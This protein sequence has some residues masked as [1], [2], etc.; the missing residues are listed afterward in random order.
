MRPRLV[1]VGVVDP[2]AAIRKAM[3]APGSP[4]SSDEV[5]QGDV[6]GHH[7]LHS[8][9]VGVLRI[10][11]D[12][13]EVMN[14]DADL[15][16]ALQRLEIPDPLPPLLARCH[17]LLLLL[18][19]SHSL[20]Q[21][22]VMVDYVGVEVKEEAA[23]RHGLLA[24][25]APDKSMTAGPPV[26]V[27]TLVQHCLAASVRAEVAVLALPLVQDVRRHIDDQNGPLADGARGDTEGTGVVGM[28]YECRSRDVDVTGRT[29]DQ[30]VGTVLLMDDDVRTVHTENTIPATLQGT[31]HSS[32]PDLLVHRS[33][34]V[35]DGE[36]GIFSGEK[37]FTEALR[38]LLPPKSRGDA[39]EAHTVST[40]REVDGL[41][42]EV[43]TE[44]TE[45]RVVIFHILQPQLE[46]EIR[47]R[48][49][50][51]GRET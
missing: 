28:S 32:A 9:I 6:L 50:E 16:V 13:V 41:V 27:H 46:V 49:Y 21:T 18:Q 29:G 34:N 47:H 14:A 26:A 45:V 12:L 31:P 3:V 10:V 22:E 20:D 38:D 40:V 48:W 2:D 51:D 39:G 42:E 43:L 5:V 44:E 7:H 4:A 25:G 23:V 37:R 24:G 1:A 17:L 35:V 33:I 30:D 15:W 11:S 36:S 19:A 8:G